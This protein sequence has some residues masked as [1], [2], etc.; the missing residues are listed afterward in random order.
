MNEDK[1][2]PGF[3]LAVD[4]TINRSV[5]VG[6]LRSAIVRGPR[7]SSG[8]LTSPRAQGTLAHAEQPA[9]A[10]LEAATAA[11]QQGSSQLRPH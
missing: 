4:T 7:W 3:P 10:R 5:E 9:T 6:F 11:V 1:G 2:L 8:K